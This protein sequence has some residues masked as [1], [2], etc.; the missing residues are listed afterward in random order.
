MVDFEPYTA[1]K[2]IDR[3][4]TGYIDSASLAQFLRE[5]GYR[6]LEP[7]DFKQMVKYFGVDG[8]EE[9]LTYQAFLQILLPCDDAFLRSSLSQRP[10]SHLPS[11]ANLPMRVERALSKLLFKEVRLHLKSDLMKREL[12]NAYD[13]T[14][15]KAFKAI[16]DFNYN[17]IDGSNLKRFLRSMGHIAS[18]RQLIAILRRFDI[19]GDAKIDLQEFSLGLQSSLSVFPK[20]IRRPKS[21]SLLAGYSS[22]RM[23]NKQV[24]QSTA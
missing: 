5:N 9:G 7:G 16:D 21:S 4:D 12:Q 11:N 17:K 18:K 14:S 10:C 1:F 22:N 2:R 19:N 6:E 24:S 13:F 20:R 23:T 8:E 3:A 15:E